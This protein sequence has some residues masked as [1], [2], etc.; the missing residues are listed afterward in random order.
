MT[1]TLTVMLLAL[2]AVAGAKVR[3]LEPREVDEMRASGRAVVFLDTRKAASSNQIP[4]S[5][6]LPPDRV[7]AWAATADPKATY[8]AYC[9]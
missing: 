7:D 6:H 9:T 8:V 1:K 3:K 5:V 4:G 2:V